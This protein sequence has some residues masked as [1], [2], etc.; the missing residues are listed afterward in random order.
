ML[1]LN[2]IREDMCAEGIVEESPRQKLA[3]GLN[4]RFSEFDNGGGGHG[5]HVF[6]NVAHEV[7]VGDLAI[8]NFSQPMLALVLTK[9]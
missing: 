5:E 3:C 8:R 6:G 4:L 7:R 1:A 2:V 9:L